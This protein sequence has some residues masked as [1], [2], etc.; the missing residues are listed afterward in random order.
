M[1]APSDLKVL[2]EHIRSNSLTVLFTPSPSQEC[3][4]QRV[5]LTSLMQEVDSVVEIR[6][7]CKARQ[8]VEFGCYI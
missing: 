2:E 3:V 4:Y 1:G 8:V 6:L 5:T 7:G